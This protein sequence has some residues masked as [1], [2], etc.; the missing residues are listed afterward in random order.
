MPIPKILHQIWIGPLEPPTE[1]MKTWKEKHPDFEYI[2]WNEEEIKKRGVE[3][4]LQHKIDIMLE[5]NGKADIMR[6]EILYKYGGYFV[7]ADSICIAPFD[8]Y[9][10]NK[11]AFATYEN[12]IIRS[13]LIATGTM[14]FVPNHV[15]CKDI[16]DWINTPEYDVMNEK[17]RAWGSVGPGVL[18]RFLK[19]GRY[20]D[21][22]VYP[23]HCFL[24]IHF[25]GL[26]YGGHKKV[27]AFQAWGTANT[28]YDK[29]NEM[30][31]PPLLREP[32]FFVSILMPVFNTTRLYLKECL[33]SIKCQK[34]YFGIE[35][36]CINDGC[37]DNHTAELEQ[38]LDDFMKK[39][40]FCR[41]VYHKFE[42]NLGISSALKKGVELCSN[43]LIFRMD[44]D[45]IMLPDRINMQIEFIKK[46]PDCV[47]VGT[48]VTFFKN[49]NPNNLKEKEFLNTTN[50]PLKLNWEDF[51]RTR[52]SWFM[53]HPTLCFR[54]SAIL[55]VG[56]YN[57]NAFGC[58][59][60]YELEVKIIK[61]HGFIYNIR[62]PLVFYRLHD[63]QLT[64]EMKDNIE[65]RE[66]IINEVNV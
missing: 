5:I 56:N 38:E 3:F 35:L 29:M 28:N 15:L 62:E 9:F 19:T 8:D 45:D 25:T 66:K 30:S 48:N 51:L 22:A 16:I 37:D 57:E 26:S 24:P 33:E 17:I 43:E 32:N 34:G 18:T 39:T 55:S 42:N 41:V 2:F 36:V 21:F 60:D 63:K 13:E 6:W 47:M 44:A 53:N 27:Y 49:E 20:K 59:E 61:K 46:N 31:L 10:S 54:K 11:T 12:E 58:L 40:R 14:G 23:S 50:H 4:K 64:H 7:D 52:P 65:L 1:M